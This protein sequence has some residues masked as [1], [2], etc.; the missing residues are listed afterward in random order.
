MGVINSK[1]QGV[2]FKFL[3]SIP[4]L[5]KLEVLN[6]I[7]E[8]KKKQRQK[9]SAT[10]GSPVDSLQTDRLIEVICRDEGIKQL[11]VWEQ[12]YYQQPYET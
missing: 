8:G 4:P 7:S 9:M 3:L 10:E 12:T 2:Q 11:R 6:W 1:V 5:P